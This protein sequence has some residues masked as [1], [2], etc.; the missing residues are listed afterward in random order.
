MLRPNRHGTIGSVERTGV[1]TA[2]DVLDRAVNAAHDAAE[3][4][5]VNVRSL[6]TLP[7]FEAASRLISRIWD[8]DEPKA[9]AGLLRALSH[10]GNFVAGAWRGEDVVGISLGFFGVEGAELHLHS[11]ITGVHPDLQG[12][13]VGFAL[14]QFQRTWTLERGART[15]QWTADPLVR[16]NMF[17]NLV[18]LG[19][20]IVAYHDDFY[21]PIVDGLNVGEESDRVVVR[22]ELTS[23]RVPSAAACLPAAPPPTGEAAVILRP[24]ADGAPAISEADGDVL[25][26]WIPEDIVE[27]R[28]ADPATAHAWR[29]ALRETAGRYLAVGFRAEA[30]TRDGWFVF[31]R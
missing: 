11:H 21:G 4:A 30:I 15:V 27:L 10:A 17:F 13:S 12:R 3:H 14:K 24:D 31:T 22:W 1:D 20:T 26:A 5:G 25:L 2:A 6:D 8:D 7:D 9:P 29:R 16:R 28:A 19:A 23:D 18:K